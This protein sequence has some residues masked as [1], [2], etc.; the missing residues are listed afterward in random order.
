MCMCVC[1]YITAVTVTVTQ[2]VPTTNFIT[3]H[4]QFVSRDI[5][6]SDTYVS[7]TNC[8]R[9]WEVGKI[10]PKSRRYCYKRGRNKA[11]VNTNDFLI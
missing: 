8:I 1:V 9:R 4:E 2:N 5:Y 11:S 7:G 6:T 10:F 3:C